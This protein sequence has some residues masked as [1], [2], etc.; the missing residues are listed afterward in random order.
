MFANIKPE[1][2]ELKDLMKDPVKG[3]YY[4]EQLTKS[5]NPNNQKH[6]FEIEKVLRKKKINGKEFYFVKYLFY[7]NKFNQWIPK[8]NLK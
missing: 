2:Y 5:P 4:K 8:L 7:P 3:F 6:F 1:L